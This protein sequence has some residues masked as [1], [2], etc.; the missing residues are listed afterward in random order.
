LVSILGFQNLSQLEEAYGKEITNAIFGGCATKAFFNPQDDVAAERFSK[1]LGDEEI[2]YKQKSRSTGGKSGASTTSSEQSSTRKLYEIS[3]FNSLPEG[4]AVVI[5][6]GFRDA[7]AIGLPLW[8]KFDIPDYDI[9]SEKQS[10]SLWYE[11]QQKMKNLSLKEPTEKEMELRWIEAL[12]IL[13]LREE[14]EQLVRN[15]HKS[16]L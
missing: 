1:F 7:K 5:N 12:R 2:K 10:V 16:V 13:P 14:K 8:E 11:T 15:I 4:K 3:Q 9:K 6:P